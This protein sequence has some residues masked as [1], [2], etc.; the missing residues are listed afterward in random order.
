MII[1]LSLLICIVGLVV[2]FLNNPPRTPSQRSATW[3]EVGRI[4]FGVGLFVF[5]LT[6][7]ASST[8]SFLR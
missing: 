5:L 2:Y 7:K 4:M 8:F 6:Y 3:A 1:Y